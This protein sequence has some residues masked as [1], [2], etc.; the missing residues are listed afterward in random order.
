LGI[1]NY[2]NYKPVKNQPKSAETPIQAMK[3]SSSENSASDRE[4]KINEM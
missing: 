4:A 2:Q 3:D 1:P